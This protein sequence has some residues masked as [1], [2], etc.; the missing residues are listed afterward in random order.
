ML[1]VAGEAGDPELAA[2][3][4]AFEVLLAH[5]HRQ[6]ECG[7]HR[8]ARF[9]SLRLPEQPPRFRALP[10]VGED[11]DTTMQ[12][13][14]AQRPVPRL[15]HAFDEPFLLLRMAEL[16]IA[17]GEHVERKL[18]AAVQPIGF[19]ED[20]LEQCLRIGGA[21]AASPFVADVADLLEVESGQRQVFE[22]RARQ[23]LEHVHEQAHVL[24]RIGEGLDAYA[25]VLVLAARAARAGR[26]AFGLRQRARPIV[27]IRL[28]QT[29]PQQAAQRGEGRAALVSLELAGKARAEQRQHVGEP[30][31]ER[32]TVDPDQRV[33]RGG[34]QQKIQFVGDD[35]IDSFVRHGR[36]RVRVWMQS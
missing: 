7:E 8:V 34:V 20:A 29:I 36:G 17:V 18:R 14:A 19:R 31:D 6:L 26:V 12:R 10:S 9:V 21:A 1:A 30:G 11:G 28:R 25:A 24:E 3:P 22:F 27:V 2:L 33:A 23:L 15:S 16:V 4:H 32:V 35:V 5:Q 13:R